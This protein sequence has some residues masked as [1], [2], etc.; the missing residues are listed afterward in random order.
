ME[1]LEIFNLKGKYIG[2][3]DRKKFYAEIKE[4]FAKKGMISRQ[5]KSIRVLMLNSKGRVFLQKRSKFKEENSGLYDKT[6]GGHARKGESF[7]MCTI[8]ECAE[9]LGFPASILPEKEFTSAINWTHLDVVGLFRKVDEGLFE[10]VR[11][12]KKGERFVQPFF[13][14]V[15]IG[16]FDGPIK[17]IDGESSGLE[18]FSMDELEDEIFHFPE[19][20][21]EDLKVMVKKYKHFL[22]PIK[23]V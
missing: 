15:F 23:S 21:T 16:Y 14:A 20:F 10:S 5:A 11:I 19:K 8:R 13:N 18:V 2:S 12:G 3:E 4:E 22:K 9:E 6:I 7:E 17:F 1:E